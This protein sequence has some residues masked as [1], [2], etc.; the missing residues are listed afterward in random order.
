[1]VTRHD[2]G[3]CALLA[4]HS[5]LRVRC[6]RAIHTRDAIGVRLLAGGACRASLMV[7]AHDIRCHALLTLTRDAILRAGACLARGAIGIRALARTAS[8]TTGRTLPISVRDLW[9]LA[10]L[11]RWRTSIRKSSNGANCALSLGQVPRGT[12]LT[13]DAKEAL[14]VCE[15]RPTLGS[16]STGWAQLAH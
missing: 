8:D 10:W 11:A 14:V 1:M 5:E 2:H 3:R 16:T 9:S 7:I 15:G 6:A 12:G 4:L 13:R